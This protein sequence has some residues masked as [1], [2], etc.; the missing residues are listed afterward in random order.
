M[1]TRKQALDPLDALAQGDPLRVIALMLWKN[2]HRE[3]DMY[4]QI[5]ERDIEGFEACVNYLKVKPTVLIKRPRIV[6]ASSASAV[7]NSPVS[8][9]RTRPRARSPVPWSRRRRKCSTTRRDL[10]HDLRGLPLRVR[11]P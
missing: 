4:V 11:L 1:A 6:R 2:R 5:T 10:F 9:C 7:P 3:P 8:S